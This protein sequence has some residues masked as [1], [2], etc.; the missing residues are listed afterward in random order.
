MRFFD[1]TIHP[2]SKV[3]QRIELMIL[4]TTVIVRFTIQEKLELSTSNIG[5]LIFCGFVIL[6]GLRIPLGKPLWQRRLYVASSMAIIISSLLLCY[7]NSDLFLYWN[8]IKISF[9]LNLRDVIIT[10]LVSGIIHITGL[11]VTYG[12]IIALSAKQGVTM[13]ESPQLLIAAQFSS[14]ISASILCLLISTLILA[15]RRSRLK[16]T[17]LTDEVKN[18]AADLERQRIAREIHDSLGHSLAALDIQ[19]EIAHK[20]QKID[21]PQTVEAIAQ[22]KNLSSQCLQDVRLAVGSIRSEPFDLKESLGVLVDRFR[23]S[24]NIHV[25]L[26]LPS[27]SFQSSH[28]LYC[29]LQE[30]FTNIQKHAAPQE[31]FLRGDYDDRQLWIQLQDDGR[32]FDRTEAGGGFGLRSMSERTQ[33]LGGQ[34]RVESSPKGTNI[35]LCIPLNNP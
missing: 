32:G 26:E 8:I 21:L 30:G 14:Y 29:I 19:L 16:N 4:G 25:Q 6:L 18:L 3:L 15:E 7:S 13:P 2:M 35:L 31:V 28:Q 27:L 17:I 24:F 10:V 1:S 5:F 20:L 23:P 34:L 33:L 12:N 22:A 11:V 9:L